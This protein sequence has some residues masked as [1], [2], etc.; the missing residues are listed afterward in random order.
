MVH[1]TEMVLSAESVHFWSMLLSGHMVH[2]F[3]LVLSLSIWFT[4]C[5]VVLSV[6]LAHSYNV[7]LIEHRGS[8]LTS[9]TVRH[10]GSLT[11]AGTVGDHGALG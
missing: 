2:S 8:L 9:G 7:V 3:G 5:P 10:V 6:V 4:P 1:F 11:I